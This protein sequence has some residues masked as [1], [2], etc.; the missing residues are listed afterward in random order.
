MIEVIKEKFRLL[1]FCLICF[2][3][4]F[5]WENLRLRLDFFVWIGYGGR[6]GKDKINC[7]YELR[8]LLCWSLF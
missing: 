5:L 4:Y 6:Y 7:L 3:C 1:N 2:F 8:G